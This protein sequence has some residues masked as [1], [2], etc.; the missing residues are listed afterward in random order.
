MWNMEV[1]NTRTGKVLATD[2]CSN[3][4]A[5]VDL[6]AE[7]TACARATWFWSFTKRAV[8]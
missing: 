2:N 3:L 1:V 6:C 7:A 5:L 8:R 4:T